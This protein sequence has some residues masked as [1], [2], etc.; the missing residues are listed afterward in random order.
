MK[1]IDFVQSVKDKKVMNTKF[2]PDAVEKYIRENLEI[3]EYIPFNEKRMIAE[4]V[5]ASNTDMVDGVKKYDSI[6]AY[7]GF[8][9]SML[10]AH[11]NLEFSTNPVADYDLLAESGMLMQIIETFRAD[12]TECDVVLKMALAQE[13][14]ANNVNVLVGKFLNG[15]SNKLDGIGDAIKNSIEQ[16]DLKEFFGDIKPEDLAKLNGLFNKLK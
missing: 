9:V 13:M 3:R 15:I 5:V 1:V 6:S 14:E 4:M 16:I 10:T 2:E 11:T 8:V 7:I 12:Y